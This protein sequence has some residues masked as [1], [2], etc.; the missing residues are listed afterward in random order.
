MTPFSA[1]IILAALA[2]SVLKANAAPF[3]LH[4][5]FEARAPVVP[6]FTQNTQVRYAGRL[7]HNISIDNA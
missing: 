2:M 1:T 4:S 3:Q 5:R 7:H 6:D